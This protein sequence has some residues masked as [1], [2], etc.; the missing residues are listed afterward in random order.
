MLGH[1]FR[2]RTIAFACL[3]RF[4]LAIQ[5]HEQKHAAAIAVKFKSIIV[6]SLHC[7]D[8][9]CESREAIAEGRE[10]GREESAIKKVVRRFEADVAKVMEARGITEDLRFDPKLKAKVRSTS[11]DKLEAGCVCGS[12]SLYFQF[13][14]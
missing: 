9:A 3:C 4:E 8:C 6:C 1:T 14:K 7:N 12:V 5:G 2:G 10:K 11:T 13:R